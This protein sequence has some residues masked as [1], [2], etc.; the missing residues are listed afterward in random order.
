[1]SWDP[2][3]YCAHSDHRL[4]PGLELA[5]RISIEPRLIYDLG[6]GTAEL[7]NH[8]GSRWPEATVIGIDNSPEML[9]QARARKNVSLVEESIET[10]QPVDAPDLIFSNA[11]LHWVHDHGSLLPRLLGM[12]KP[13]GLLAVQMPDN[14]NAPTH[15]LINRVID[16]KGWTERIGDRLLRQPVAAVSQYVEWLAG[17]KDVDAW[18]TTYYQFMTGADPVLS[19]VSGTVLVPVRSALTEDELANLEKTLAV[20]YRRAYP[21]LPDGTTLMPMSRI[22]L[23]ARS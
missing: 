7:T 1:M 6:C 4:R 17:A 16:E 13:G 2:G 12:L 19:W 3:C 15:Q 18:R 20:E 9:A 10:W 22:F 11:T 5:A 14:W 23:I 21:P 8:L